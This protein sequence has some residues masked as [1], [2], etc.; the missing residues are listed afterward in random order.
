MLVLYDDAKK[1]ILGIARPVA[2]NTSAIGVESG[3]R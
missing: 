1:R 3:C 2:G